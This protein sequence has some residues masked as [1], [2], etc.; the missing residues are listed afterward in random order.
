MAKLYS[1][2]SAAGLMAALS[3][4]PAAA[5]DIGAAETGYLPNTLFLLLCGAL[6]MF[7]A[8]GFAMLEAGS[9]RGKSVTTICAK[10]IAL[11]AFAGIA[12]YAIRHRK[13]ERTGSR[14]TGRLSRSHSVGSNCQPIRQ[15]SCS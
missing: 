14:L 7:M 15:R 10:N 13:F 9:V 11:Y 2:L 1:W 4:V 6:V 3:P 8:A 12:F 5:A